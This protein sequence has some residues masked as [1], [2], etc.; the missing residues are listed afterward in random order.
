MSYQDL[1]TPPRGGMP[2]DPRAL[3]KG[4]QDLGSATQGCVTNLCPRSTVMV[5]RPL[6]SNVMQAIPDRRDSCAW[7]VYKGQS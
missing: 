5:E 6:S 2:A 7:F 3:E 4:P 1:N